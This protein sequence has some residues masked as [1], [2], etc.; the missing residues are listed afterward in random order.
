MG[1]SG[2]IQEQC[3]RSQGVRGEMGLL[4][5]PVPY[6]LPTL[7]LW[8]SLEPPSFLLSS[9]L[10]FGSACSQQGPHYNPTGRSGR[11]KNLFP[12]HG[13]RPGSHIVAKMY[14]RDLVRDLWGRGGG[15]GGQMSG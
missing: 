9:N 13:D 5:T 2:G 10:S 15:T 11:W 12:R 4:M 14:K 8:P 1:L 3:Q 7:Q 6:T